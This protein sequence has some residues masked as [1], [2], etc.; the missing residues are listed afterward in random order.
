M[1]A[2]IAAAAMS[3]ALFTQVQAQPPTGAPIPVTAD[4][5]IRAESDMYAANLAKEAGGLGKLHHR[6]EP[7]SIDNQ[8]VIRLNRDTLYT[9]GVFDLDAGPVTI[10]LPDTGKRFQSLQTIS[11]DHYTTTV[12]GA[13]P[14][15]I[16][17]D[18]VGTRYAVVGIRTLVDPKDPKDA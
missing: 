8:T 17:K 3:L 18:K 4:N 10:A 13:G 9:S 6:R 12:Y 2:T 11:Q 16:D 15:T 5:F 14:H 1:K 7:A